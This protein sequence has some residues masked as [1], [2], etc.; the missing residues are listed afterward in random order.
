MGGYAV[1]AVG[2]GALAHDADVSIGRV[3]D[4]HLAVPKGSALESLGDP[5]EVRIGAQLRDHVI[6]TARYDDTRL[7]AGR[8]A[9]SV[10]MALFDQAR[11]EWVPVPSRVTPAFRAVS[12]ETRQAGTAI[13]MPVVA[14]APMAKNG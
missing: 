8:G 4:E 10:A 14:P 5:F 3:D 6:I 13:W 12:A 2:S 1:V 11:H 9:D 7:P